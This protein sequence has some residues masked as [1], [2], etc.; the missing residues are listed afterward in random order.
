MSRHARL[1]PAATHSNWTPSQ[2]YVLAVITLVVGSLPG[3]SFAAQSRLRP[4]LPRCLLLKSQ[5]H[6]AWT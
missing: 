2:A 3:I 1:Q 5:L 4:K 6:R